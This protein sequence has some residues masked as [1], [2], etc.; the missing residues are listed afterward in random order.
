[1][2]LF[3][4]K[5][6][7]KVDKKGR[8]SVP[9]LFRAELSDESFP[10]IIAR[11]SFVSEAI[12][13]C[14][15]GALQE[16]QRVVG[17]FNPFTEERA[18]FANAIFARSHPVPWD[19]EGRVIVPAELLSHAAITDYALFVGLGD[20]FQVWEPERYAEVER[21]AIELARQQRATLTV[22]TTSTGDSG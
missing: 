8:V 14:G 10:G 9:A 1:M 16:L 5:Y 15:R 2:A 13:A 7:N 20:T 11:P 18:G 19:G 4:S 12:D 22:D 21:E 6:I 17:R 3:L